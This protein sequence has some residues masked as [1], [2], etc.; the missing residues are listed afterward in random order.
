VS[1]E[2][3]IREPHEPFFNRDAW[4]RDLRILL[5]FLAYCASQ[6]L[7]L[8][9]VDIGTRPYE[10]SNAIHWLVLCGALLYFHRIAKRRHGWRIVYAALVLCL[11]AD[12][13]VIEVSVW[14][15]TPLAHP[16]TEELIEQMLRKG[17][18]R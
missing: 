9:K 18:G 17:A 10:V 3:H 6:Y 15:G 4:A 1:T 16:T 14:T 13:A 7:F 5:A 11:L 8:S 12:L 2:D